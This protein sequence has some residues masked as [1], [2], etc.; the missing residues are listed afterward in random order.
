MNFSED[1][2][3]FI[4]ET[5][6]AIPTESVYGLAAPLSSLP[7]ISKIFTIKNR[8]NSNPLIIHISDLFQLKTLVRS[9]PKIYK[10]L[11][12]KFWPGPLTLLFERTLDEETL[13]KYEYLRENDIIG[14][15]MP[16]NEIALKI[17][18]CV[19]PVCAPSSNLS[20]KPSTTQAE[21]VMND[22]K[23][24]INYIIDGGSSVYGLESTIF[25]GYGEEKILRQGCIPEKEILKEI[26]E[27]SN[28]ILDIKENEA[29]LKLILNL[30]ILETIPESEISSKINMPVCPG[31]KFKHYSP[32]CDFELFDEDS[33]LKSLLADRLRL[34][35]IHTIGILC[36]N[37]Y[38]PTFLEKEFGLKIFEVKNES[39]N[40]NTEINSGSSVYILRLGD[41]NREIA[42]N[43]FSGMRLLDKFCSNIYC[44]TVVEESEGFAIMDRINRAA[45]KK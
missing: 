24:R 10:I 45:E 8:P 21:H 22:L 11:I 19:G 7:S 18:D 23:G 6:I 40:I 36:E 43:L 12:K 1:L 16:S 35:R 30:G 39:E 17:I 37:D 15:R 9:I 34:K 26:R 29:K 13:Q 2:L 27:K 38:N 20:G 41:T 28:E 44:K 3:E 5:P 25:N 4:S 33:G 14:I 31:T 32:G 42:H